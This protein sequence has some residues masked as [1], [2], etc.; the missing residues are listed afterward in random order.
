MDPKQIFSLDSLKSLNL[1]EGFTAVQIFEPNGRINVVQAMQILHCCQVVTSVGGNFIVL[2][3]DLAASMNNAMKR[4]RAAIKAAADYAV[5]ILK[6]VG[7]DGPNV[8]YVL[9]YETSINNFDIFTKFAQ[10]TIPLE[11]EAVRKSLPLQ[12][13]TAGTV[14]ASQLLSPALQI[15]ELLSLGANVVIAPQDRLP[16]LSFV[17]AIEKENP[18]HLLAVPQFLRLKGVKATAPK[19][20]P[21]NYIFFDDTDEEINQKFFGAFCTDE[22][23][24]NP[25]YQYVASLLIWKDG[26]FSFNGKD[27]TTN[28][29]WAADFH[30]LVKK[31]LKE[32][33]ARIFIEFV[34][35]TRGKVNIQL[36]KQLLTAF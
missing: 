27:Y 13:N 19:Q 10:A 36:P 7:V 31:D 34:A 5:E 21:K 9:T 6:A 25:I 8:R 33:I 20:E 11:S 15:T 12:K 26:K 1:K 28:E 24:E 30:D 16:S 22:E 32:A 35:Q 29:Q 18:P 2:V 23:K 4:D 14:L 17:N 3:D